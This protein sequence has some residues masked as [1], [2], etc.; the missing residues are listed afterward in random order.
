MPTLGFLT[1]L[2]CNTIT[3]L[4]LVLSLLESLL[5]FKIAI[6]SNKS[7]HTIVC[8]AAEHHTMSILTGRKK[9]C[10]FHTCVAHLYSEFNQ[11]C[12]RH[13]PPTR[14]TKF[15]AN[16]AI[17]SS[18]QNFVAISLWFISYTSHFWPSNVSWEYMKFKLANHNHLCLA[19]K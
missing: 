1:E 4:T 5:H 2:C 7:R 9:S 8:H 13:T 10:D 17:Q 19:L 12:C 6:I 11:I 15:E 3:S 14:H 16:N 18:E